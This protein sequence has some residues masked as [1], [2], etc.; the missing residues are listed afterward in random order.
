MARKRTR[1]KDEIKKTNVDGGVEQV[2]VGRERDVAS[3]RKRTSKESE[4]IRTEIAGGA[5]GVIGA[6]SV[7]I[8]NLTFYSR[9][10][11]E[12]AQTAGAEPIGPCPYPG[13]A[14]FGPGDA[15]LFFGRDAAITRLADA[16]GRQGFTAL[17]GASGS[18]KSSVVLAGL[19]PR[20]HSDSAG[21]WR[22]S[23]FRIGTEEESNPFMA[24]ARALVP[25]Y[26][27][28]EDDTE[29]LTNTKKLALRLQ[30]GELS[31]RDVFADC[32][33]RNKGRRIL[34][35]AD[36]FEEAF[37]LVADDAIRERFID[38][39]LTGFPDPTA[40]SVPD[41][42]LILT[43]RADF[44]GR[45]LRHRP[46]ADA[47]QNH[48]ENLGPMNREEL[49]AAI[50]RPAEN[51]GVAFESGM[52]ETLLDTVQS[53]PGGLPL[54]QFALRE[55]WG[56]QERKKITRKSYD[57][58]GGVE[59]ALA[60]RAETVFA[61]L[62]KNGADPAMDKAFQRLFTRLVTLGEG[63]GDTRRIVG[64]EELGQ[65]SWALAQRL[66][67]ED[68]RLIVT[69]APAPDHETAEVVHE[70]LIRH[71]PKLVE[72][73]SR[74]R[75]FQSWLRQLKLRV[76]EWREHPEDNG[77][78][79]RGGPL[80][81]AEEWLKRRSDEVSESERNY[82]DLSVKHEASEREQRDRLRRRPRQIRAA[83]GVLFFGLV[84]GLAWS[85][86][87]Y[88][89]ARA[90]MLAEV[91]WPRVLTPE[92]E[93]ALKRGD[94]F[95]ECA[96]CPEMV[97]VPAGEFMMGSPEGDDGRGPDEG[98]QHPVTIAKAFA[99][100]KFE[101]RFDEWDVCVILGGCAWSAIETGWGRGTRPVINVS[102]DDAQQYVAWL[103]RRTGKT[104]RLLSEAEWEYAARAGNDKTYSWGDEIGNGNANC[105]GCGSQ[106]DSNL[107]AP[108]G[109][110]A[111][112]AFGLHDM[113]G[114]VMEWVQDCYQDYKGAPTD[115]TA[116]TGGDCSRRV[117]RG[118]SWYNSPQFLR[119]AH[120]LRNA[121]GF[122]DS[123]VGFRVGRT[124]SNSP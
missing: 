14:H 28:S 84:A 12:P 75:A 117:A 108:V 39:L 45:A 66:A 88:L 48:V 56:R 67:G 111:A 36:Q 98:P 33:S 3:A 91:L 81:V 124:L 122:R 62:T 54:L 25:L 31:L 80:T 94:R 57:D 69:S 55:M 116:N 121:T 63:A 37:T 105:N 71:W 106:W 76:D 26:V 29:R 2:F 32:R 18:G 58:I 93:R 86:Q 107:T 6:Q 20:L 70:A 77:T 68:N 101:V 95:Q 44:Y 61:G 65:E 42:C 11:A 103:S 30:Q 96:D 120:R 35:I 22:F 90:V 74:D 21:N 8:E 97:V 4:A 100:S 52:V 51:A 1:K 15:D 38:V 43:M 16:V 114:N 19:A 119:S 79:L 9:A 23:H 113:H 109:S 87:V 46:L 50:V 41:I 60:Q 53:K 89:K 73:V 59:G 49:Q 92:A 83:V 47:L 13:L 34:L 85:N 17:V 118:G 24:L 104:Y 123:D 82:I 115:G 40:G 99:V 5:Q 7:T 110:F 10:A 72:W 78:L 112:N 27:A 64:R 102:W